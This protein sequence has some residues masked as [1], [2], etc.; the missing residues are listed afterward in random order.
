MYLLPLS[1]V[2][3]QELGII[4]GSGKVLTRSGTLKRQEVDDDRKPKYLEVSMAGRLQ[5]FDAI[6]SLP[7]CASFAN[8]GGLVKF[9]EAQRRERKGKVS[10]SEASFELALNPLSNKPL[11]SSSSSSSSQVSKKTN[12]LLPASLRHTFPPGVLTSLASLPCPHCLE[13]ISITL[14]A[15]LGTTLIS[16]NSVTPQQLHARPAL[17]PTD[18]FSSK[19]SI[20]TVSTTSDQSDWS[21]TQ[22]AFTGRLCVAPTESEVS[23]RNADLKSRL[24]IFKNKF[25]KNSPKGSPQY[26]AQ[27]LPVAD[28]R[29]HKLNTPCRYCSTTM[30][31][32]YDMSVK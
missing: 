21:Q 9:Y 2:P 30:C 17:P 14:S 12:V 25:C 19:D 23:S 1:P 4:D 29:Y 7:Q 27:H 11:P 13:K 16:A 31:H 10:T 18:Q 28:M 22:C 6:A 26:T 15:H 20:S 24:E 32:Y 3:P 8:W 5:L